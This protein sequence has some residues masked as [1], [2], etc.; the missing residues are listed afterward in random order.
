MYAEKVHREWID[1]AEAAIQLGV[2]YQTAYKW[3]RSGE[4]KAESINGAYRLDP[5]IVARFAE[6]RKRPAPRRVRQPREGFAPISAKLHDLLVVGDDRE[7]RRLVEHLVADGVGMVSL[8]DDVLAPAMR[9]IGEEWA[10]GL[11]TIATEHRATVIVETLL[12]ANTPTPRGRRRGVAVVASL[13]NDHH[14]LATSMAAVALRE[15]NWRVH[16]LGADVPAE[17]LTAF[18]NSNRIDLVV[19][20]VINTGQSVSASEVAAALT[21][22]ETRVIVGGSGR[23]VRELVAEARSD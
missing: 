11:L 21:V 6:R 23:T 14:S 17:E 18:C 10:S 9:L 7:A 13:S 15:D 2:H 22:G 1:L 4:L 12:A 3:V 8:I 16:N 20:T 19:I 5:E